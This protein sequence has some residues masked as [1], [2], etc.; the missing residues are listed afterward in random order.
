[1]T[2]REIYDLA[3]AA[4]EMTSKPQSSCL[5]AWAGSVATLQVARDRLAGCSS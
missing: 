1:M 2:A 3:C 5:S 4:A